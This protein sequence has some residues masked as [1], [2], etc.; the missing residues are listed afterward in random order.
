MGAIYELRTD[1]FICQMDRPHYAFLKPG[2]IGVPT[3]AA[4]DR[5]NRKASYPAK[6]IGPIRAGTRLRVEKAVYVRSRIG[7]TVTAMLRADGFAQLIT[8]D[9]VSHFDFMHG[10]V[11]TLPDPRYLKEV[12]SELSFRRTALLGKLDV[13]LARMDEAG[14]GEVRRE[15]EALNV[16]DA[17]TRDEVFCLWLAAFAQI[18]LHHSFNFSPGAVAQFYEELRQRGRTEYGFDPVSF[19]V[20]RHVVPQ[21]PTP[22]VTRQFSFRS[23]CRNG[24]RRWRASV[25]PISPPTKPPSSRRWWRRKSGYSAAGLDWRPR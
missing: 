9:A 4:W 16:P 25:T 12:P 7:D 18:S 19:Q 20:G 15:L 8:P 24:S 21:T 17:L 23:C 3:M 2:E 5:G 22:E 1:Y 10:P 14:V 6:I 11:M 13:A